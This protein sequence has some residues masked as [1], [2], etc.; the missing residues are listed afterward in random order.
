LL[1]GANN[2]EPSTG[3]SNG[4]QD[5]CKALLPSTKLFQTQLSWVLPLLR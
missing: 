5:R 4:F 2:F 1:E 3:F